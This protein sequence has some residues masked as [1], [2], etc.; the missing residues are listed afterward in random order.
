MD[1]FLSEENST[2]FIDIPQI[3]KHSDQEIKVLLETELNGKI[4]QALEKK[5][6]K[7]ILRRIIE[8]TGVGPEQLAKI[9]GISAGV[10][11]HIKY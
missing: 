11:R 9:T 10:I 3:T 7:Q 5:L 8:I 2:Q 4:L 6:Q 1:E